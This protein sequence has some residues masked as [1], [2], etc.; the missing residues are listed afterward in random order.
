VFPLQAPYGFTFASLF[1]RHAIFI[2]SP[3]ETKEQAQ[4][5]KHLQNIIETKREIIEEFFYFVKTSSL[6]IGGNQV[7]LFKPQNLED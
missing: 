4:V 3:H 2:I 1:L 6:G 5:S 7:L